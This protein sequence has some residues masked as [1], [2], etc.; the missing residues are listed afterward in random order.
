MN[1]SSSFLGGDTIC[2]LAQLEYE[3]GMMTLRR[4]PP[5]QR[6]AV[7]TRL[8]FILLDFVELQRQIPQRAAG[9]PQGNQ[10]LQT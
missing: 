4:K 3:S 7:R 6:A 10:K 5:P 9:L 8:Q 2:P 1:D